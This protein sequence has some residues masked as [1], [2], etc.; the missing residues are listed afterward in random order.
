M[1]KT[2]TQHVSTLL[3]TQ[4]NCCLVSYCISL[5]I[6]PVVISCKDTRYSGHMPQHGI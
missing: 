1:Y 4:C 3:N 5:P 6:P 2:V